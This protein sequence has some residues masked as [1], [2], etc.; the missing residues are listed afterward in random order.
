MCLIYWIILPLTPEESC[1]MSHQWPGN[2]IP[3]G[4]ELQLLH[5]PKSVQSY[6]FL[7][8]SGCS[9]NRSTNVLTIKVQKKNCTY[10]LYLVKESLQCY[11]V[12]S[13]HRFSLCTTVQHGQTMGQAETSGLEL[14]GKEI[15]PGTQQDTMIFWVTLLIW[16]LPL[17]ISVAKMWKRST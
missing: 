8:E 15:S 9:H 4:L 12:N 17:T 16:E 14:F 6:P 11:S 10:L 1:F 5:T 2:L 3:K 7:M 13:S